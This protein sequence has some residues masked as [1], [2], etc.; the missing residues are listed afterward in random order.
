M[1]AWVS[2]RRRWWPLLL[3]AAIVAAAIAIARWPG[4]STVAFGP[5]AQVQPPG[6]DAHDIATGPRVG[7]LA[8]NFLLETSTGKT[9]RLSDLRGRPVFLNFWATW[10]GECRDEMPAMQRLAREHGDAVAVVGVNVGEEATGVETFAERLGV[11]YP[12]LLDTRKQVA[13]TYTVPAIPTSIFV[14][15]DGVIRSVVFGELTLA[16]ME[17]QVLPLLAETA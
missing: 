11:D 6:T 17:G 5:I 12:L 1:S 15:A 2:P 9:L 13:A 14:D 10:C 7:D 8:P 3:A 4:E 16:D